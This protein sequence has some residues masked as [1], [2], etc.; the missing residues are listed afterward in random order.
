MKV[1]AFCRDLI[2]LFKQPA[3]TQT[4]LAVPNGFFAGV[5]GYFLA[6]FFSSG[7]IGISVLATSAQ[8]KHKTTGEG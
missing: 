1:G 6:A 5:E 7:D 3:Y 2:Q 8:S 4:L